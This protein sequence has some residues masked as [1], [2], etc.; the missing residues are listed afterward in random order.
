M[1]SGMTLPLFCQ[2]LVYMALLAYRNLDPAV[3]AA[4]K[5]VQ[6]SDIVFA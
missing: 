6:Y 2:A 3:P 4:Y 5:V 1:V